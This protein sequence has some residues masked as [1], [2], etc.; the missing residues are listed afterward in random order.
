MKSSN[1][2]DLIV[3]QKSMDLVVEIYEAVQKLPQ[4]ERFE[5]SSQIRRAAVSIPRN[6]AEGQSRNSVKEFKNFLGIA[7]GSVSEL[8]TQLLLAIRINLLT[9]SD[10]QK[11]L[12]L[13]DEIQRML[14]ALLNNLQKEDV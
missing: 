9:E 7:R 3:W 10:V 6:I 8:E 12:S 1:Y 11:C 14:S 13:I 5:L 2:K 4:S